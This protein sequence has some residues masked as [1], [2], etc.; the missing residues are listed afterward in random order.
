MTTKRALSYSK[1]RSISGSVPFP[2]EPKPIMTMGPVMRPCTGHWVIG[3]LQR[4]RRDEAKA[5]APHEY[6]SRG[7]EGRWLMGYG[8]ST[9]RPGRPPQPLRRDEQAGASQPG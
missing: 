8:A 5:G 9:M 2:I 7:A 3:D 4:A 6:R 1:C